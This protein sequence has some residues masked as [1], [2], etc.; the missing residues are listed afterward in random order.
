MDLYFTASTMDMC[1]SSL[2]VSEVLL[3]ISLLK[4][5]LLL[6]SFFTCGHLCSILKQTKATIFMTR[7]QNTFCRKRLKNNNP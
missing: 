6:V 5:A 3:T 2:K 1:S 7:S 4:H